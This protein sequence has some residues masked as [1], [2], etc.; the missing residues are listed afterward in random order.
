L[1]ADRLVV[2]DSLEDSGMP[3]HE[4]NQFDK[5]GP[6]P[7][8]SGPLPGAR[9]ALILLL[10]I[11]LFN[12]IDRQVLA[13]VEPEIRKEL[14]PGDSTGLPWYER[15]RFKMGLLSSA[16]L[17]SF[18]LLS[19]LFGRLAERT[20]RWALVGVGVGLWSLASGASGLDWGVGLAMAFWLLLLTRC[21]VGIGEAAYG[22]VA[23]TMISDMYPVKDRGRILAWFYLAIPVGGALGYA[24]GEVVKNLIDWRWAFYLVVPPGLLLAVLC[25]LMPEPPRGQ[26]EDVP[27]EMKRKV[28][29]RDYLVL[30]RTPSWVLNTM[31][32]TAMTFAIGG[33]AFW[34]PDF[35]EER[36]V[37]GLSWLGP[38]TIFGV[39]TA[40][41]GLLA[42]LAG[43]VAGDALRSRFPG[44]YFLVSAV[45]MMLGCPMMLLF[46]AVP[47]PF[48]WFF[49]FLTV[50][51]LFFNTGPTNTILANVTHPAIRAQGF[52]LNILI[53]HALG[54]VI[55]PP[56]IG[57]IAEVSS[58]DVAFV[59]MSLFMLIGGLLWLWGARYLERDTTR[60][61]TSLPPD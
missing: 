57:A 55:S 38:R 11:N 19:P 17:V 35:L 50:F 42:T 43:G 16:F 20:S 28:T 6:T 25:F 29:R 48:A 36:Q 14:L 40:V 18:M 12:Y 46:L 53:I 39:I 37:E 15:P 41:S 27:T 8:R 3:G 7:V 13:A 52:A 47:F 9:Q 30:F 59:V 34:M 24:F 5:Q 54:D 58:M 60:A 31:G 44:S 22:P 4:A 23:P 21:F 2:A 32:M 10:V 26:A 33:I 45:A 49:G 56:V 1:P 51:C 61:P